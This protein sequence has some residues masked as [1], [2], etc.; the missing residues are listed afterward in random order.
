MAGESG[1]EEISAQ[2][3]QVLARHPGVGVDEDG[4]HHDLAWL[5]ED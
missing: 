4:R 3:G 1:V 5:P 2:E